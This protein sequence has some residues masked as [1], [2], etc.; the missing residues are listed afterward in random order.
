MYRRDGFGAEL[1]AAVM[2]RSVTTSSDTFEQPY[3]ETPFPGAVGDPVLQGPHADPDPGDARRRLHRLGSVSALLRVAGG[4]RWPPT[5][6][7]ATA[8]GWRARASQ[9]LRNAIGTSDG[10]AEPHIYLLQPYDPDRRII[11]MLH[12][13]ASSPEA[14]TRPTKCWAMRYRGAATR[15]GRHY[16]TNAPARNN[17]EIRKALRRTLEHRPHVRRA[18]R[19]TW[20]SSVTAWAAS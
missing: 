12:G 3:S 18:P 8:R 6:P 17:A 2:A 20:S 19:A 16:P 13:L 5:S 4:R 10:L 14:W 1:V 11:V 7:P 9:A 15:S